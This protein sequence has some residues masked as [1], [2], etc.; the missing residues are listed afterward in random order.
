MT[1]PYNVRMYTADFICPYCDR[2]K[3]LLN[4]LEIPYVE[5]KGE[6]PTGL[7]T[8]PQIYFGLQHIGGCDDLFNLYREGY[9]T[10]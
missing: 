3:A 6:L 9:F 1:V 4:R 2:A 5:I 8:Y 10:A 7:E